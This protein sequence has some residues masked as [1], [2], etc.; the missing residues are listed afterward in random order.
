[1]TEYLDDGLG[2]VHPPAQQAVEVVPLLLQGSQIRLQLILGLLVP[3]GEE[4]PADV[5]SVD[6]T[7][8]IT[9]EQQLCVL[10]TDDG[11]GQRLFKKKGEE[12]DRKKPE[13][14]CDLSVR[15]VT[16]PFD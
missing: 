10:R 5:Q 15:G 8:L 11:R 13:L 7:G 1:M 14:F 6:E 3:H 16:G 9:L 4:L 12:E 2:E